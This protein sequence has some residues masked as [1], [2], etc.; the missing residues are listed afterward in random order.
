MHRSWKCLEKFH[1]D[2]K[3]ILFLW[4]REPFPLKEVSWDKS[5]NLFSFFHPGWISHAKFNWP[6]VK[7]TGHQLTGDNCWLL[8]AMKT[9]SKR[10]KIEEQSGK[11]SAFT[12]SYSELYTDKK[13][14]ESSDSWIVGKKRKEEKEKA[15]EKHSGRKISRDRSHAGFAS[16][17]KKIKDHFD[18]SPN[19][20]YQWKDNFKGSQH[21]SFNHL[22]M[23]KELVDTCA[24]Y[25]SCIYC[26]MW[27]M[28]IF[29]RIKTWLS[30][31]AT[32]RKLKS[33]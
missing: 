9:R 5:Q 22:C 8:Q 13:N 21:V 6:S 25:H 32:W 3:V 31:C 30:V 7:S 18:R 10:L 23:K 20:V 15:R 28:E 12:S 2:L 27:I 26:A 14:E 1:L 33:A 17:R 16:T 24:N 19:F 11:A 4:R 29:P